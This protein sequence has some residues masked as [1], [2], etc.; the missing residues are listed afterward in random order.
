[1]FFFFCGVVC[2]LLVVVVL[3]VLFWGDTYLFAS[4]FVT[5]ITV[6]HH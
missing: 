2:L 6:L 3:F 4:M 5:N 1:M